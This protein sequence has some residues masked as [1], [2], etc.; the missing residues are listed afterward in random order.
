MTI[1]DWPMSEQPRERLLSN[2]AAS[3]SDAELLAI[4]LRTGTRGCTAVDLARSLLN[5][6]G[7]LAGVL[8]ANC[9]DFCANNGLGP[10]KFALFQAVQELSQRQMLESLKQQDVLTSSHT[11]RDYLRAK[12]RHYENEVFSCL[13]LDNQHHIL[14][15][16]EL[17]RG[18]IDGAAVYPREVV[19]RC[20][21][22]N[23]AAIIFA[24][25]HP[26]GI[27]EPS[28][29]DIAITKKLQAALQTIDV[30][31]LDHFVIGDSQVVSFAERNLL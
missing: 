25:N 6:F 1:A 28:Q 14:K 10:G 16:E 19:K 12:F 9:D 29:A 21:S 22:Y 11:T 5:R 27:A 30:R 26:S 23:A 20:L 31:V 8:A 18:T 17:F 2:G 4:L 24:H 7:S 13:Y 3:L 15:L